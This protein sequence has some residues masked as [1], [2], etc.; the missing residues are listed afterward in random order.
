MSDIIDLRSDTVT[1]PTPAMRQA[2]FDAELGDDVYGE[3]PT[4]NRLE[5]RAAQLVGKEAALFVPTGTMGNTIGVKLLTT[6]GQE[7]ICDS[8]GHLLNYE[9][10]MAAWFAGCLI[11]AVDTEDGILTWEKIKPQVRPLGRTGRKRAASSWRTRTT[12]RAERCI[13]S[14]RWTRSATRR[15]NGDRGSPGRGAHFQRLG[16]SGRGGVED[17]RDVDR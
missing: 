6:H 8:R 16:G 3:D 2:M 1:R 5:E 12:W 17:C 15:I 11:R 10:S 14:K 4:V 7:I 9:L 13:R